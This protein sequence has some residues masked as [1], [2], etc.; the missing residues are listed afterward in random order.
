MMQVAKQQMMAGA[1][2]RDT[3]NMAQIQVGE[4]Y[5][6]GIE[7]DK[8]IARPGSNYDL[9]LREGDRIFVPEELSTVRIS[10]AVMFPN[11]TVYVPGK[12]IDYYIDAAGGYGV[13]ARRSRAY[14][15]YMNGR[16]QRAGA[17]AKVEP[18]CEI[19]VPQRPERQAMSAGEVMSMASSTASLTTMV[20]TLVNLLKK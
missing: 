13:R 15:V 3:L 8:A 2:L 9:I 1:V 4:T 16:V 19:I 5:T 6:V 18:G 17:G 11:T 7:L 20:I 14:I 10:G 12:G